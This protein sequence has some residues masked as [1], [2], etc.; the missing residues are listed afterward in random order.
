MS[1]VHITSKWRSIPSERV[2]SQK[3]ESR[4]GLGCESLSS[5]KTLRYRNLDRI[6]VSRRN[7]FLGSNR[8][9]SQQIRKRNVRNHFPWK[10]WAQSY[11]GTCCE[12]KATT[13]ACCDTFFHFYSCSW[14]KM[15]RHQ[16]WEIS[17]RLFC[18]VKKPWSDYC[19]IIHQFL[20]KIMEQYDLTILWENPRQNSMVHRNGQITIG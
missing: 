4:P 17:S 20:E 6:S 5:W 1:R 11:S 8:E 18:S 16:S 14:K 12:G 3:H 10:W 2:D 19:D 13:K 7:S 9:R 15:D